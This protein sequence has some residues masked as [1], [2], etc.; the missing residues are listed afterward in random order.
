MHSIDTQYGFE[1][2]AASVTRLFSHK[3]YAYI[4]IKTPRGAVTVAVTPTG[5]IR[6]GKIVKTIK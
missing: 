6:L 3:G 1:F 4:E 5:L 2:G